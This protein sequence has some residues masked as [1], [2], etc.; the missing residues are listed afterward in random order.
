MDFVH[1][2]NPAHRLPVELGGRLPPQ[3]EQRRVGSRVGTRRRSL[4][5]GPQ[6]IGEAETFGRAQVAAVAIAEHRS[7]GK[8]ADDRWDSPT[9]SEPS[10]QCGVAPG[11][12]RDIGVQPHQVRL[13]DQ[14]ESQPVSG[15]D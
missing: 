12:R 14:V 1:R 15:A 10:D 9:V 2:D 7:V 3:D 5:G 4:D 6:L 11:L 8:L 13:T